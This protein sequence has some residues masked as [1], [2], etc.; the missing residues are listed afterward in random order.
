[1]AKL[2]HCK[3]ECGIWNAVG[4]I[5]AVSGLFYLVSYSKLYSSCFLQWI[6]VISIIQ[7]LRAIYGIDAGDIIIP[8]DL[9]ENASVTMT[10][11]TVFQIIEGLQFTE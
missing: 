3:L 6:C 10:Q 1:M 4:L 2:L 5:T 7:Y 8:N 9:E 11:G